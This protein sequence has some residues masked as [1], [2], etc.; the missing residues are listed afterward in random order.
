MPRRFAIGN[1]QDLVQAERDI[2]ARIGDSELDF[3]AMAAVSNI[4]RAANA[5]RNHME[6]KVLAEE[7][8]SWAAFTVLFVLWIWGDQQT[9][10][11]AAEAGVTKGTLTGVLKTLEKRDLA[12]R[13]A[14]QGDGRLVLV[15][16]EP[17]GL[18]IIERLF[19]AFNAGEALVSSGLTD[20][21]KTTL[22]ALLRKIIRA[23]EGD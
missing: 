2:R 3:A 19:P 16:L 21:E 10:H 1:A 14:H 22:A 13:R 12:R 20:E 18:E 23:I 8:L 4:Y 15:S 11:L 5:I 7:D 9:R 17:R 6:Q